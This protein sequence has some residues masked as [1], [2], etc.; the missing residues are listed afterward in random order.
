MCTACEW[1]CT[2]WFVSVH[3]LFSMYD[4]RS[5]CAMVAWAKKIQN[6]KEK[7]EFVF[8]SLSERAQPNRDLDRCT[9]TFLYKNKK[10]TLTN[11]IDSMFTAPLNFLDYYYW[12]YSYWMTSI[13]EFFFLFFDSILFFIIFFWS[14]VCIL[15]VCIT[16][17]VLKQKERKLKQTFAQCERICNSGK[18]HSQR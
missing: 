14:F 7:P 18:K 17:T 10:K 1:Y 13:L 15:W 4:F 2:W 6:P 16:Q 12:K 8:G 5:V 11:S 3:W 9:E